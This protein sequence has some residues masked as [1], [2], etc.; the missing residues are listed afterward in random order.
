MQ[1]LCSRTVFPCELVEHSEK[2]RDSMKS[3]I[4]AMG[5]E[6]AEMME[7]YTKIGL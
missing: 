7:L 1:E 3:K 4:H 5:L 6:D 2:I